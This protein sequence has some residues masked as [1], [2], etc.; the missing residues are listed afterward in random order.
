MHDLPLRTIL[1]DSFDQDLKAADNIYVVHSEL[2]HNWDDTLP[3]AATVST[4]SIRASFGIERSLLKLQ[5]IKPSLCDNMRWCYART[6]TLQTAIQPI[7][8]TSPIDRRSRNFYVIPLF[9]AFHF[10]LCIRKGGR[11]TEIGVF[12]SGQR[13]GCR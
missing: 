2:A 11:A 13:I 9:N 7:V 5:I 4:T 1:C 12:Q 10:H 6:S 8:S 3:V